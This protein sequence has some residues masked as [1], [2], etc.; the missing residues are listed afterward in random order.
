MQTSTRTVS[1]RRSNVCRHKSLYVALRV[2]AGFVSDLFETSERRRAR[3]PFMQ[4]L[5]GSFC[6][7]MIRMR[8]DRIIT[9]VVSLRL[10]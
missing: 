10:S 3:D 9:I 5:A 1:W 2:Q 4:Q 8:L 7:Q 6:R